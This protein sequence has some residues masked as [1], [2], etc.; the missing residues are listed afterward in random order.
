M[1]SLKSRFLL[2]V[3]AVSVLAAGLMGLSANMVVS[4]LLERN[5]AAV[6]GEILARIT[7]NLALRN[8]MNLAAFDRLVRSREVGEY[9][10]TF[11]EHRVAELFDSATGAFALLGYA[12]AGGIEAVKVARGGGRPAPNDISGTAPFVEGMRRPGQVQVL[13]L[14]R[15]LS[16][17]PPGVYYA[18]ARNDYFGRFEGFLYALAPVAEFCR[19]LEAMRL[20]L[21][22]MLTIASAEGAPLHS[23][24]LG[25]EPLP[26]HVLAALFDTRVEALPPMPRAHGAG[27]GPG[28][29]LAQAGG[30]ELVVLVGEVPELGWRC[31]LWIP[32][33]AYL[34]PLADLHRSMVWVGLATLAAAALVTFLLARWIDRQVRPLERAMAEVA[35]GDFSARVPGALQAEFGHLAR[36]YNGMLDTLERYEAS[37]VAANRYHA[38]LIAQMDEGLLVLDGADRVTLANPAACRIL[39]REPGELLGRELGAVL[40]A[41]RPLGGADGTGLP[42]ERDFQDLELLRDG[43]EGARNWLA[44]SCA[45]LKAGDG[46]PQGALCLLRDITRAKL[47][48]QALRLSVRRFC[49]MAG[50]LPTPILEAGADMR[51]L[52]VN[53]AGRELFGLGAGPLLPPPD[54][55]ALV[56]ARSQGLFSSAVRLAVSGLPS[57]PWELAMLPLGGGERV[58]LANLA[59]VLD[60]GGRGGVRMSVHDITDRKRAERAMIEA[61]DAAEAA[62]RSKGDFVATMSHELRSPLHGIY[63]ALQ[64]LE[65]TGLDEHQ[66]ALVRRGLE[67]CRSLVDVVNDV[68]DISSLDAGA[69]RLHAAPFDPRATAALVLDNFRPAAEARGLALE[70]LVHDGVP[71]RV[72]ADEARLRQVL[73]NLVANAVRFT[74]R[75]SVRVELAALPHRRPDGQGLLLWSVADTGQGIP[76]DRQRGVFEAFTQVEG[77]RAREFRGSG[78]GLGIVRRLVGLWGGTLAL[79]SEHGAGTTVHFTL[80]AGLPQAQGRPAAKAPGPVARPAA[81]ASGRALRVLVVD[82]EPLNTMTIQLFLESLGHRITCASGGAEALRL[83]AGGGFDC[84]LMDVQMAGQD[85]LEVTRAIRSGAHPGVDSRVPVVAMTAHALPGDRE[86]ILAAGMDG[87]IAKPAALKDLEALLRRVAAGGGQGGARPADAPAPTPR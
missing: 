17:L 60:E 53:Q 16:G 45:R 57:G 54:L 87:Y 10:Q 13:A 5:Q 14:E 59:P 24:P 46:V 25:S 7:E 31:A 12:D 20:P 63:A 71:G 1:R 74:A 11:R 47:A 70:V 43:G 38:E 19:T 6:L 34:A 15:E 18:Q 22:G 64:L 27:P 40:G 82:D 41:Y 36:S 30:R 78:L 58:C 55:R 26:A 61:R 44:L 79:E 65:D 73:F 33:E 86:R 77:A 39:G 69:L 2:T 21:P 62:N 68:L 29:R 49:D 50:Q 81:P 72:V 67:T 4:S 42:V 76:D 51:V 32:R 84:V 48:E 80:P 56:A 75:G 23:L 8:R 35:A 37:L 52:Y 3:L 9:P 28:L 66:R 85:G 83:L